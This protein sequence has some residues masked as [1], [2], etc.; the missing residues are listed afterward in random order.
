MRKNGT[1]QNI[2]RTRRNVW[3]IALILAILL[4]LTLSLLGAHLRKLSGKEQNVI[5]L[6]CEGEQE[7]GRKGGESY[8][9]MQ[10]RQAMRNGQT[11]WEI[12]TSVDL[13]QTAYANKDGAFTVQSGDGEK[14]IAPGTANAY[15][16]S[17]KNTTDMSMD[18]TMSV[19]SVFDFS[20][21]ELPMQVRLRSGDRW[22]LGGR[23]HGCRPARCPT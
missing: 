22:I 6:C 2:R 18:Y 15:D 14:I 5:P 19:R 16:F 8:I 10:E 4:S 11:G 7:I 20:N 9:R 12:E 21:R 23:T 1:Q 17:L 13:F 3:T